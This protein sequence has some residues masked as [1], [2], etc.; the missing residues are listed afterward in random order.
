[1][2]ALDDQGGPRIVPRRIPIGG[3]PTRM[4]FSRKLNKLIVGYMT[5]EMRP[6]R[7]VN[8]HSRSSGKRFLRPTVQVIDP[9]SDSIKADDLM[10]AVDH[11]KPSPGRAKTLYPIGKPGERILGMLGTQV[12]IHL[13]RM[14]TSMKAN[15]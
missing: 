2:A 13:I 3:T 11:G 5:L 12:S 14:D 6:A 7:P 9:D 10:D 15:S 1:M 8:G 4:I